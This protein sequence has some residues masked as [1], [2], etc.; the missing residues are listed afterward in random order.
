M[1]RTLGSPMLADL[2]ATSAEA[3]ALL[4]LD[5]AG[6]TQYLTNAPLPV[7]WNS[8]TW[9]A[10]G[11]ALVCSGT[12]E[13]WEPGSSMRLSLSGVDPSILA[14]VLQLQY[15]GRRA[16]LWWAHWDRA[17][18]TVISN[19]ALLF[20][21]NMNDAFDVSHQQDASGAGTMTIETRITERIS[22]V[23]RLRGIRTNVHSH[24][25]SGIPGAATD[26]FFMNVAGLVGTRVFWNTDAIYDGTRQLP[27]GARDPIIGPGN[28][29]LPPPISWGGW[30]NLP[31][32]PGGG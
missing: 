20:S 14:L 25:A 2:G 18:A 30:A 10:V 4:E 31:D 6:A 5:F 12:S 3:C 8:H 24:Q 29:G 32:T 21:G 9:V 23:G 16:T 13:R 17:T 28:P 26:T 15:R 27:H 7:S 1:P 22:D 11:G 19:P